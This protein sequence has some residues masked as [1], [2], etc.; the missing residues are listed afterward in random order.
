MWIILSGHYILHSDCDAIL[1]PT[2]N[3]VLP[4]TGIK[5]HFPRDMV[6]GHSDHFGLAIPHLY[7]LQGFLHLS[8]LIKF[9]L[10]PCTTGQLICQSY[11]TL[12]VELGLSGELLNKKNSNWAILCTPTWLAHTW[13]Y[14]SEQGWEITGLPSLKLKCNHDCCLQEMF[15]NKGYR[16]QQLVDLNHCCLWLQVIL[17]ADI[18]DGHSMQLL[19][20]I[21]AGSKTNLSPLS[22][23]WPKQASPTATQWN[24]WQMAL[25][26][27]LT[28][29]ESYQLTFSLSS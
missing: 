22:H 2:L 28:N 12:Q 7:N 18:S 27:S 29:N 4:T 17:V 20:T 13:Q 14:A 23:C 6:Y 8:A 21:L 19:P 24:L 5:H 16:G 11:E 25:K 15:W 1:C 9:G 10:L 3:T 26:S